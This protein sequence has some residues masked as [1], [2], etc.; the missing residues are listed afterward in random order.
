[1]FSGCLF[2]GSLKKTILASVAHFVVC[3]QTRFILP[4]DEIFIDEVNKGLQGNQTE[5][6]RKLK[7]GLF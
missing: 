1:M 6:S 2:S 3:V 7:Q 5:V 4:L